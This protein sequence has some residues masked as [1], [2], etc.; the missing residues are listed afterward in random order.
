MPIRWELK[1][2]RVKLKKIQTTAQTGNGLSVLSPLNPLVSSHASCP[3]AFFGYHFPSI[4]TTQ[5]RFALANGNL[6]SRKVSDLKYGPKTVTVTR[7][8]LREQDHRKE[9]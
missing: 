7:W 9:V 3:T 8:E 1:G 6:F 4:L 5:L 2:E